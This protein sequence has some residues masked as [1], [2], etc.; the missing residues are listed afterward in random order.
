MRNILK[1][2]NIIFLSHTN[3]EPIHKDL[4]QFLLF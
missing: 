1:N 4:E 3:K 2:L